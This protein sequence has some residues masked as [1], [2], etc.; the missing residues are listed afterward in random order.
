[1]RFNVTAPDG[2]IIPVDAP[3]GATEQDAIAFAAS[4]YKPSLVSQ[5]PANVDRTGVPKT[6]TS[7]RDRISGVIETPAILAGSIGKAIATPLAQM[8]GEAYKGYGTPQGKAYGQAVGKTVSD[9]FYQPRTETGPEIVDAMGKALNALPPVIGGGLG[10]SL[11]TVIGPASNQLRAIAAPQLAKVTAPVSNALANL[12]PTKPMVGM[13]AASTR[14]DLLR[15][16][17][18]QSQNIRLT[19]GEQ[20]QDLAQ[21]QF[22]S[23]TAKNFPDTV[24]KPLLEAKAGQKNDILRRI[25][26]MA[27]ETG[28]QSAY[29]DSEGYRK[30]GSLVDKELVAAYEKKKG[31]VD[32]AY[33]KARD[34]GETKAVVD[35]KAI[36]DWLTKNAAE[37][38]SVPEINSI[39]AKLAEFK[40][41]K[42]GQVT[43][44]DIESIYQVAGKLGKPGETSGVFMKEVKKV[45]D[46]VSEGAGGDLYKAARSQRRELAK[47]FDDNLRVAE[48]LGTKA[49]YADRKVALDDV[50]KHIVLDGSKEQ[51][52][53]VAVLLKNAGPLGQK[54]LK[55]GVLTPGQQVWADLQGQTIQ[56]IKDQLTKNSSG[57]LSY[58]KLKT[59]IDNLDREGKLSYLFGKT[60]R[61]KIIDFR[62]TVKDALVKPPGAVNY[63]NTTSALVRVLDGLEKTKLPFTGMA[64]ES[65]RARSVGK[66]VDEAIN[67]NALSPNVPNSNA[68]RP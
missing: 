60:G 41:L 64:A 24:G 4:T 16:E 42:N 19:K 28:A 66:K 9:Q 37:A 58:A 54:G 1:M 62:E 39:K 52:Q 50:F 45:L 17:R 65:A 15:A 49:G 22:E 33:Q 30:M 21:L 44:D 12:Q 23:E 55:E 68:L 48:L 59:T 57:Q 20:Q 35:T 2:S 10:Q 18:A 6:E 5:I 56:H 61:D 47:Q 46:Q 40:A 43:V 32:A 31:K 11:S 14:E 26:T 7:W 13:G 8:Y 36:D 3:P 29:A 67:F 51:M 34:S 53:N 25:D 63:S 38:L 27:E